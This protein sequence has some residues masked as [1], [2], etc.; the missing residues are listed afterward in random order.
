MKTFYL[1]LIVLAGVMLAFIL[2]AVFERLVPLP[3]LR[4]FQ[5]RLVNPAFRW[6][7]GFMPGYAVIETIGVRSGRARRVPVGGGLRG[8]AFWLVAADG[9]A[10]QYVQNIQA[11]PRVRVRVHGRWRTGSAHVLPDDAPRRRLR[12]LNPMNGI[13]ISVSGRDLLT[14]RIDLEPAGPVLDRA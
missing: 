9:Q 7:A 5:R 12:H 8:D 11:N 6:A 13:F 3:V 1:V 2:V 4:S 14:V 10:A